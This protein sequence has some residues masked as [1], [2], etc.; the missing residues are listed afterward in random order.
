[1]ATQAC[2]PKWGKAFYQVWGNIISP[3]TLSETHRLYMTLVHLAALCF[4][5]SPNPTSSGF[6][7]NR[8]RRNLTQG[9]VLQNGKTSW[10]VMYPLPYQSLEQTQVPA[11][12]VPD[13]AKAGLC[14]CK[15]YTCL[16]ACMCMWER[17][18]MPVRRVTCNNESMHTCYWVQPRLDHL[19][20]PR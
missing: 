1:M 9:S 11:K 17:E 5:S 3:S 12:L 16:C 6:I 19:N 20:G 2:L 18:N 15:E 13:G 4:S 10:K 8:D 14:T 7:S